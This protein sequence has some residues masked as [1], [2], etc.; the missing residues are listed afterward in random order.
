MPPTILLSGNLNMFQPYVVGQS[1]TERP[2]SVLVTDAPAAM[3]STVQAATSFAYG[4]SQTEVGRRRSEVGIV[5]YAG[6]LKVNVISF[7]S[8]SPS[9]TC[10]VCRPSFS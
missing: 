8:F 7:E 10:C 2:E 4:W 9:V 3:S 6:A 5:D 1:G